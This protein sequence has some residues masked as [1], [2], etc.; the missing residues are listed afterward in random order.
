MGVGDATSRVE[1]EDSFIFHGGR[2]KRTLLFFG[3]INLTKV[4]CLPTYMHGFWD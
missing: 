3:C 2:G 4:T 1:A